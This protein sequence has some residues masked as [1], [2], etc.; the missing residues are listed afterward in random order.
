M[1]DQLTV[2]AIRNHTVRQIIMNLFSIPW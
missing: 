1:L 2:N